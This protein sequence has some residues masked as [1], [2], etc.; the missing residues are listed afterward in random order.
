LCFSESKY[1]VAGA[2]ASGLGTG[3]DPAF[4][5]STA[6]AFSIAILGDLHLEK[7][8]MHMFNRAR[9][10]LKGVLEEPGSGEARVVQLGDLG[11]YNEKP[12]ECS[13]HSPCLASSPDAAHCNNVCQQGNKVL[14]VW[15]KGGHAVR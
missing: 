13:I 6:E 10:Q 5:S 8:G 15:K 14:C 11:G 1:C 2:S 4:S 3:L 12:G 9:Q 7:K